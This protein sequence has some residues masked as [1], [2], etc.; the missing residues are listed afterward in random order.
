MCVP[1]LDNFFNASMISFRCMEDSR[2]TELNGIMVFAA[3]NAK[4]VHTYLMISHVLR[5]LG[6]AA[7]AYFVCEP[8]NHLT[9][10]YY[11]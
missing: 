2:S 10:S 3:L 8:N 9:V 7:N 1:Y 6:K 4:R 11:V 5:S